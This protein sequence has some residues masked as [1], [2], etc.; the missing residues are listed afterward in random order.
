MN[1][2]IEIPGSEQE[3][4]DLERRGFL[5]RLGVAIATVP[6]LITLSGSAYARVD[7]G[8]HDGDDG[9]RGV[10]GARGGDIGDDGDSGGQQ[11]RVDDVIGYQDGHGDVYRE[12]YAR[13]YS[14]ND[15]SIGMDAHD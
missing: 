3:S 1:M 10:S 6:V 13:N 5:A 14:D 4:T 8:G 2:K 11:D 9:G 12:R 7:D 15:D